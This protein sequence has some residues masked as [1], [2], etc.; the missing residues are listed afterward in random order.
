MKYQALID[1]FT[2]AG[3]N[4]S[5]EKF[6][7][8]RYP[9]YRVII[10]KEWA[11]LR[12]ENL[13]YQAI[14]QEILPILEDQYDDILRQNGARTWDAAWPTKEEVRK[15]R[16]LPEL[17]KNFNLEPKY[18]KHLVDAFAV[19]ASPDCSALKRFLKQKF[20]SGRAK[21][22]SEWT[23][24]H[25]DYKIGYHGVCDHILPALE[26]RF[27]D[28]LR[29]A[30]ALKPGYQPWPTKEEVEARRVAEYRSGRLGAFR[31][32]DFTA[33]DLVVP[34]RYVWNVYSE[35]R[36]SDKTVWD[37]V[38]CGWDCAPGLEEVLKGPEPKIKYHNG[39]LLDFAKQLGFSKL[40]K[41]QFECLPWQDESIQKM[42]DNHIADA[43]TYGIGT[44]S[45]NIAEKPLTLEDVS[46]TIKKYYRITHPKIHEF[47]QE[48]RMNESK[49]KPTPF[50]ETV[51]TRLLRGVDISQMSNRDI[52]AEIKSEEIRVK[53][54]E[55]IEHK[56]KAT[57]R[58]IA[59]RKQAIAD[60]VTY[61]DS[62][63]DTEAK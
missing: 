38:N 14:K 20:P 27:D 9:S 7:I 35:D 44:C 62:L 58:E 63:E 18:I 24:R 11:A 42:G 6:L 50:F 52:N 23:R 29:A 12:D 53:A 46:D 31:G 43:L 10:V 5:R 21:T 34:E 39:S 56:T 26:D 3:V 41:Q 15:R 4:T 61:L 28:E 13:S 1:A 51:T 33:D 19:S 60:V 54:L 47:F 48:S 22:F 49:Q 17:A 36:E 40:W 8:T 57:V 55:D 37:K 2:E 16:G 25:L 32:I 59:E 45:I 30:G